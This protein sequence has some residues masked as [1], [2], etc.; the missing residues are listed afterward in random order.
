METQN[1]HLTSFDELRDQ[2]FGLPGTP[3]RLD[4]ERGFELF[5]IGVMIHQARLDR[6]MSQK[7][8]AVKCGTTK[9]L[10]NKIEMEA[11]NS[12]LSD[13]RNVIENGLNGQ[14]HLSVQF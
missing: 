12:T 7:Q 1:K 2:W 8:L 3:E 9:A 14:F 5:K 10:I 13:L 11:E 6:G 4:H